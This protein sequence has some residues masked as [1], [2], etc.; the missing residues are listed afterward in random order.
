MEQLAE[1][2]FSV[3]ECVRVAILMSV[4][5]AAVADFFQQAVDSIL[6]QTYE[7]LH[8]FLACDGPLGPELQ[9]ILNALP[10]SRV[11]VCPL[12]EQ[13]GLPSALNHLLDIVL[14]HESYKYIAR[15]D[16]DDISEAVRIERQVEFLEANPE[17][18]I[19]GTWGKE[20]DS[21]NHVV[22]QKTLPTSHDSII[23]FM[24]LRSPMIHASVMIRTTLFSSGIRY[25]PTL[26]QMQDYGLWNR[27][28]RDGARMANLDKNLMCIRV[29]EDFFTRRSG[30]S[31]AILEVSMRCTHISRYQLW[32]LK[33]ISMLT[34]FFLLRVAPV[35]LKRAAYK[36][37][38]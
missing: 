23:R 24:A 3:A 28:L 27:S 15:M 12:S 10:T 14:S 21:E 33:N 34:G 9:L 6:S 17:I 22:Y 20:I 11:T 2:V 32:S 5:H 16:A 31:R 13:K 36:L 25:D 7:D 4:H 1:R 19:L 18:T 37:F 29:D 8:L 38:R 30:F 35:T 26:L